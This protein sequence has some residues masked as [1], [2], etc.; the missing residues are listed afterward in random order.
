MS[1]GECRGI[2]AAQQHSHGCRAVL[3]PLW[4]TVHSRALPQ[5][6]HIYKTIMH[7]LQARRQRLQEDLMW[8]VATGSARPNAAQE[9]Q[10]ANDWCG[11]ALRRFGFAAA[12]RIRLAAV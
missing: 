8:H 5:V 6:P 9:S 4:H 10:D 12:H 1:A 11:R 7:T 2:Q 3:C